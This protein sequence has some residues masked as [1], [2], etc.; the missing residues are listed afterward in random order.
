MNL[1]DLA[2]SWRE[3][4]VWL[5][6]GMVLALLDG[7]VVGAFRLLVW[8]VEQNALEFMWFWVLLMI[9]LVWVRYKFQLFVQKR[10]HFEFFNF[11]KRHYETQIHNLCLNTSVAG[12]MG[13]QSWSQ[14]VDEYILWRWSL[15]DAW[16]YGVQMSLLFVFLLFLA[17]PLALF[18]G[19]MAWLGLKKKAISEPAPLENWDLDPL[20]RWFDLNAQL[21]PQAQL[22][23]AQLRISRSKRFHYWAQ[24]TEQTRVFRK[25]MKAEYRAQLVSVFV[26]GAASLSYLQ[27]WLNMGQML[28]VLVTVVL[29]HKPFKQWYMSLLQR[30]SGKGVH[31]VLSYGTQ[32]KGTWVDFNGGASLELDVPI[33]G[34]GNRVLV[35]DFRLSLGPG[36]R[37]VLYGSSGAGKTTLLRMMAGLVGMPGSKIQRPVHM[38]YMD[39]NLVRPLFKTEEI[40]A[41]LHSNWTGP[42]GMTERLRSLLE[43]ESLDVHGFVE[44][45]SLS[46]GE[47][48]RLVLIALLSE[49]ADLVI[50]DEPFSKLPLDHALKLSELIAEDCARRGAILVMSSHIPL[51]GTWWNGHTMEVKGVL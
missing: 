26:L 46:G 22:K 18:V 33:L 23:A 51:V 16:L 2:R 39:Q 1:S 8:V 48:Q 6:L 38:I 41:L 4:K 37:K 47:L 30:A 10:T 44:L 40:K 21:W 12:V 19:F 24:F 3:V 31:A 11:K 36:E 20:T 32:P 5:G 7:V 29:M 50:L 35:K 28:A 14:R 42:L 9:V 34:F 17:W 25:M 15:R 49:N 43:C 13:S 27:S 45:G